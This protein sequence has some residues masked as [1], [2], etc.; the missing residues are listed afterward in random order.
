MFLTTRRTAP[1]HPL[2]A[3]ETDAKPAPRFR[4]C[5][6]RLR[7]PLD[8]SAGLEAM[9]RV[10]HAVDGLGRRVSLEV[11]FQGELYLQI[12]F[13]S[14]AILDVLGPILAAAYP[15]IQVETVKSQPPRGPCMAAVEMRT[16]RP[17]SVPLVGLAGSGG[18]RGPGLA[19]PFCSTLSVLGAAGADISALYQ[20][21]LEPIEAP[22]WRRRAHELACA[23]REGRAG[24]ASTA[25][26]GD[27][28][29]AFL[30]RDRRQPAPM[31]AERRLADDIDAKAFRPLFHTAIRLLCWGESRERV[32]STARAIAASMRSLD[33]G[34]HNWLAPTLRLDPRR[35]LRAISHRLLDKDADILCPEE[36]ALTWH[37]PVAGS[38]LPCSIWVPSA[39]VP[40]PLSATTGDIRL[41]YSRLGSGTQPIALAARARMHHMYLVGATGV[42]K[43]TLAARAIVQDLE[44]GHGVAVL[45]PKG[46]LTDLVLRL[47][48]AYRVADVVLVDPADLD[49]PVGLNP[50]AR[51]HPLLSELACSDLVAIFRRLFPDSWGPRLELI[52][53]CSVATLQAAGLTLAELP[54]LL[55]HDGFRATAISRVEEPFLLE[56]WENLERMSLSQR[57]L[58][59]QPVLTR[60]GT[61][62]ANPLIRN[63]VGQQ[64]GLDLRHIMDS[65]RALIIPL[66]AGK[67]GEDTSNLLGSIIAS[68][69]QLAAMGRAFVPA[70]R[71]PPFY[72]Y[73]DEFQHYT[74]P[75]FVRI[76]CEGRS[77]GL[78]LSLANQ[79]FRQLPE[80][81]RSA[82]LGNVG[83]VICFR[84]G[85]E[86]AHL[87]AR[88]FAPHFSQADLLGLPNFQA[89]VR[90]LA[91]DG[92]LD[93]FT[94]F[95]EPLPGQGDPSRLEEIRQN[96]RR[97]YA[98]PR[99]DV[100]AAFKERRARLL[101]GTARE[102]PCH[103]RPDVDE[104]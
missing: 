14:A 54:M 48:P 27:L 59:V 10:L 103:R 89:C 102:G 38:S 2:P 96:S 97:R 52:L 29:A 86:D 25:P 30:G 62:L 98:R 47:M 87:L 32:V 45:E 74:T 91:D 70:E 46:D 66:I 67:I 3:S 26:G 16:A 33:S 95:T 77:M 58:A 57:Q 23:V 51:D 85:E 60:V 37:P 104:E 35:L 76:L 73:I 65:G 5:L 84:L 90:M 21:T 83:T 72:L 13:S 1:D 69:I 12:W 68:Q 81:V 71:R 75:T 20:V 61:L 80:D 93:S 19:S 7:V 44:A 49:F 88:R 42:G 55:T 18:P 4:D 31:L 8:N 99:E 82:V 64:Q 9:L 15:G 100:E 53:R 92:R 28:I 56:F 63:M 78:G 79:H 41:G 50:L 101:A 6:V 24:L 43:T 39:V 11:V 34:A 22:G 94:L 40:P 36:V 17:T